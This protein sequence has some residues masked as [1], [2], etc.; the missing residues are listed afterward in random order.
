MKIAKLTFT[1]GIIVLKVENHNL[2]PVK[3][4]TDNQ[5][6]YS[7]LTRSCSLNVVYLL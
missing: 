3:D 7:T 5:S 4:L 2:I 6:R 1:S